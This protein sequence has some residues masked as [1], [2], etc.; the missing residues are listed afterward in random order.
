MITAVKDKN[1]VA[2][3]MRSLLDYGVNSDSETDSVSK[4]VANR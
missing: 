1:I 3:R 4:R 2:L